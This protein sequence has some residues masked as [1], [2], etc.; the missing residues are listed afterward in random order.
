VA[1]LHYADDLIICLKEDANDALNMKL[2]LYLHE[3]MS[4]LE[5][6]LSEK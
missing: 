1:A 4:G 5:K 6:K 3:A 2:L